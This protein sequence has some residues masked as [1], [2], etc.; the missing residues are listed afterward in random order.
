MLKIDRHNM[1]I[2]H[3]RSKDIYIITVE[4]ALCVWSMSKNRSRQLLKDFDDFEEISV[5]TYKYI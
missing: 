1:L 5:N 2:R 4:E 3:M